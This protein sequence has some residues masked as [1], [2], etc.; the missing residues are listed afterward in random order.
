MENVI[1]ERHKKGSHPAIVANLLLISVT[2]ICLMV[3]LGQARK[4]IM[5]LSA[6]T[7]NI[8]ESVDEMSHRISRIEEGLHV[9]TTNTNA[10]IEFI[11][12][13]G[14][15]IKSWEQVVTRVNYLIAEV[16]AIKNPPKKR[17]FGG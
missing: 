6:A 8:E 14:V 1:L 16:D 9:L 15:N 12:L 3:L 10:K 11:G 7:A 2:V 13:N 17:W 5:M 4:D